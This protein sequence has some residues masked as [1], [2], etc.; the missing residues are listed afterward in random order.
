MKKFLAVGVGLLVHCGLANA[1]DMP[2][3]V[4]VPPAVFWSWTGLYIGGHV[5]GGF[6]TTQFSDS[7]GPSIYGGNENA[8][9]GKTGSRP[10]RA[11]RTGVRFGAKDPS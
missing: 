6:G 8:G 5:G 9:R 2:D 1:A 7:A 10:V 3:V 11:E 4:V